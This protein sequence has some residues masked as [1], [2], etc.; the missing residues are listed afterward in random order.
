MNLSLIH[1]YFRSREGLLVALLEEMTSE[2]V[3]RQRDMYARPDMNLAD[4]WRTAIEF[5]REDLKSGYV[6]VVHELEAH[7]F[8]NP[9]IAA[10]VRALDAPWRDLLTAVAAD[11]LRKLNITAVEPEEVA[12]MIISYW[13]GMEVQHLL[14][15]TEPESPLWQTTEKIGKLIQRLEQSS[16]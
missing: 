9:V 14:G 3:T 1:Y 7:G 4:K 12:A 13:L 10:Q 15:V 16:K 8:S 2:L 11:A 6:R 5:Y